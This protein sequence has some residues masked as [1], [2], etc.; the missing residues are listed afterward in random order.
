MIGAQ[1]R[2]L[3]PQHIV[4]AADPRPRYTLLK[5]NVA[6]VV[7]SVEEEMQRKTNAR[8]K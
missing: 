3:P 1:T 2:I 8:D 7:L 4:D 5:T 6:Y